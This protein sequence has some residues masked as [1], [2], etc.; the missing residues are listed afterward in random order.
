MLMDIVGYDS[1]RVLNLKLLVW[2]S[3]DSE[4]R[5]VSISESASLP[6]A[7]DGQTIGG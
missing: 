1:D 6:L 3:T 5:A 4:G 2:V 7:R